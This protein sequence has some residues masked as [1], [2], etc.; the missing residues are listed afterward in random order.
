MNHIDTTEAK[1]MIKSLLGAKT[2]HRDIALALN[3]KKFKTATGRKWSVG[4]IGNIAAKIAKCG[5]QATATSAS[6]IVKDA[7]FPD[8]A[9]ENSVTPTASIVLGQQRGEQDAINTLH[10][11]NFART[12]L[13]AGFFDDAAKLEIL[14]LLWGSRIMSSYQQS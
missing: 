10:K 5:T 4:N 3:N 2:S 8:V 14:R 13:H 11:L 9:A 1:E 7:G 12:V 6:E